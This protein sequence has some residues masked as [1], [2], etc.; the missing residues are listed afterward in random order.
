MLLQVFKTKPR[1]NWLVEQLQW[2]NQSWRGAQVRKQKWHLKW[3]FFEAWAVRWPVGPLLDQNQD[4]T[5]LTKTL[6][7][8][9]RFLS[10]YL[11]L[12]KTYT[13]IL[14]S[15]FLTNQNFGTVFVS[16][17]AQLEGPPQNFTPPNIPNAPIV[18]KPLH[19]SPTFPSP[20]LPPPLTWPPQ[21]HLGK[22]HLKFF[23]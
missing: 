20:W 9:F 21:F 11:L 17:P 16:P 19:P 4:W 8:V 15:L 1:A 18:V 6:P 2:A 10:F 5:C 12:V 22:K 7:C 13:Y 23:S 14:S 3:H